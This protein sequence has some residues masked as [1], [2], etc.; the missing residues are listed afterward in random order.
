MGLAENGAKRSGNGSCRRV[1]RTGAPACLG[2]LNKSLSFSE[3]ITTAGRWDSFR[4]ILVS[5]IPL[6][7]Y[8]RLSDSVPLVMTISVS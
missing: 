2:S 1:N 4:R 6:T 7:I 3:Q 5:S 8:R